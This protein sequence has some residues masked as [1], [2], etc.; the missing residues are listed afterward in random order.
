VKSAPVSAAAHHHHRWVR[1][2]STHIS[3]R[4]MSFACKS[5]AME[6]NAIADALA[7]V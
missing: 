7:F 5:T 6:A 1:D 2:F 4:G 3:H